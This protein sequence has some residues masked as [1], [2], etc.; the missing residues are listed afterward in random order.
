MKTRFTLV[1]LALVSSLAACGKDAGKAE[2]PKP[3]T[4]AKPTSGSSAHVSITVTENGFEPDNIQVPAG[5][6]V[7]LVFTRKTDQTCVKDVVIAQQDGTKIEKPL[8]L[9]QPV[10]IVTT[11]PKAGTLTYACAMDMV[12]GTITVQ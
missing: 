9:D 8:P 3:T 12:K 10:E 6:P 5:K 4:L 7:S 2:E 11:F 1:A